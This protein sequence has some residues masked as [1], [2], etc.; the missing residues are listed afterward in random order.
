MVSVNSMV[1]ESSVARAAGAAAEH[2]V[3]LIGGFFLLEVSLVVDLGVAGFLGDAVLE[4]VLDIARERRILRDIFDALIEF[5]A[6]HDRRLFRN[7]TVF[8]IDDFVKLVGRELFFD[9]LLVYGGA[10]VIRRRA[11]FDGLL[12]FLGELC[13]F[14]QAGRKL[15]MG[16]DFAEFF[17]RL[18]RVFEFVFVDGK[19]FIEFRSWCAVLSCSDWIYKQHTRSRNV[20]PWGRRGHSGGAA[21]YAEIALMKL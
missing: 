1:F 20:P 5:D 10:A 21:V 3:E 17:S 8:V 11:L 15:G 12:D 7:I 19:G 2:L 4:G 14:C 18:L 16:D 13:I 6:A 9:G